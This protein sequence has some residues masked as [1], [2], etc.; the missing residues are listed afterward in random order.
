MSESKAAQPRMPPVGPRGDHPIP[1][2]PE[3]ARIAAENVQQA[4]EMFREIFTPRNFNAEGTNHL[5]MAV[6]YEFHLL[7]HFYPT[8][9]DGRLERRVKG[10]VVR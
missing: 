4:Y 5:A 7:R 6:D 9:A 10:L 2:D 3:I 8:R 1:K